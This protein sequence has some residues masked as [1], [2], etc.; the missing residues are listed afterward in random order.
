M[1]TAIASLVLVAAVIS[2]P[3]FARNGSHHAPRDRGIPANQGTPAYDGN[4]YLG[5]D[6]DPQ[7]RFD[8]E[9]E[10]IWRHG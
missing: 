6:P 5:S 9:R 10:S 2:S 4:S 7:I 1:K 3:A 8:L